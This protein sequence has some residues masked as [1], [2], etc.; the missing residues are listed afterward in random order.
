MEAI[1]TKFLPATDYSG[2]RVLAFD[3]GHR[4]S[5][6]YPHELSG[7]AVHRAAAKAFVCKYRPSVAE[8]PENPETLDDC[9]FVH[10]ETKK[11]YVF[12]LW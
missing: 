7:E 8:D 3:S 5:I 2:A 9:N 6:P 1:F 4:I 11:G 12:I 10:A